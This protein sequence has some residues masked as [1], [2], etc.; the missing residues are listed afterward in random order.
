MQDEYIPPPAECENSSNAIEIEE[1]GFMWESEELKS[2]GNEK[3]K[4]NEKLK[5]KY[6]SKL[7]VYKST[8]VEIL[9]VLFIVTLNKTLL[10]IF[11]PC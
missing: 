7:Q 4:K 1:A 9:E 8:S 11:M 5:R 3:D 2:A 10:S 6:S